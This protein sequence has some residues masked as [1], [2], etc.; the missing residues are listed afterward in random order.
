MEL[1]EYCRSHLASFK[2]P[3]RIEIRDDLPKLPT[4]KILRRVLRD[5][6]RKLI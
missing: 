6:A 1:I 2:V 5:E 3:A 4:G